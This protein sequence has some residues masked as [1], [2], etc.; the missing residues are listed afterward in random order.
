MPGPKPTP[1]A[2]PRVAQLNVKS[3]SLLPQEEAA[4]VKEK[5]GF[6]APAAM[7]EAAAVAAAA[8]KPG[9]ERWTIKTGVDKDAPRVGTEPVGGA[10]SAGIVDTTVAEMIELH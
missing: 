4:K 2:S 7:A 10:N 9:K 1:N 8:I 6:D 5:A 3:L